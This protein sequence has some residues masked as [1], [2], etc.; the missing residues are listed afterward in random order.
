MTGQF[1]D[2]II[3]GKSAFPDFQEARSF[4]ILD[5]TLLSDLE[6]RSVSPFICLNLD[7]NLLLQFRKIRW[8]LVLDGFNQDRET[9]FV[10]E[11]SCTVISMFKSRI[12]REK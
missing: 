12:V 7:L 8:V 1:I 4:K 3:E 5:A 9:Q 2:A 6:H 11:F 10:N